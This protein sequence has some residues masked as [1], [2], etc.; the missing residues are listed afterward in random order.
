MSAPGLLRSYLKTFPFEQV[1]PCNP[2]MLLSMVAKRASMLFR[3]QLLSY[4][5]SAGVD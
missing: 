2:S 4:G 3:M 5:A 1:P